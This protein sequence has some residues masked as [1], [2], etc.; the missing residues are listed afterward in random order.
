MQQRNRQYRRRQF[1]LKKKRVARYHQA[2]YYG[3]SFGPQTDL[4]ILGQVATT[5]AGCGCRICA[6]HRQVYGVPFS[7]TRRKLRH[8]GGE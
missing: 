2:N 3:S 1:A 4:K 8:T 5:P 7:E 6:N